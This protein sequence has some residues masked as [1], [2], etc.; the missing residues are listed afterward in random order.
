MRK[1]SIFAYYIAY[2]SSTTRDLAQLESAI[3]MV[4]RTGARNRLWG[5]RLSHRIRLLELETF[6]NRIGRHHKVF[7]TSCFRG[8]LQAREDNDMDEGASA[9]GLRV[10][11]N[12]E[13]GTK[14]Q[15]CVWVYTRRKKEGT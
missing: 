1:L 11:C 8:G 9:N 13:V 15:V 2:C 4:I 10:G 6:N 7:H 14:L 3:I 5:A 12:A